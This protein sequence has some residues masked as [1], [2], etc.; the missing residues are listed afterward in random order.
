MKKPFN[1]NFNCRFLAE[2][3]ITFAGAD[4]AWV[5]HHGAA[6]E[7]RAGIEAAGYSDVTING[8]ILSAFVWMAGVIA[9]EE[10]V[11]QRF[12][13]YCI[14]QYGMRM[15]LMQYEIFRLSVP[16]EE[17]IYHLTF[18][19]KPKINCFLLIKRQNYIWVSFSYFR[20]STSRCIWAWISSTKEPGW[21]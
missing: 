17:V 1:P 10:D 13:K 12:F 3:P 4:N 21:C 7:V 19:V 20:S 18:H 5:A 6:E 14:K 16:D 9:R 15:P 8:K 11:G 2:S